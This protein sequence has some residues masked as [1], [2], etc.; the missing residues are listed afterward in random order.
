MV[1]DG[2]EQLASHPNH[3]TLSEW[4]F[5]FHLIGYIGF[6]ASHAT[7]DKRPKPYPYW[8]LNPAPSVT[9]ITA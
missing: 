1:L 3:I 7:V 2:D 8:E 6:A 4:F 9:R 5:I